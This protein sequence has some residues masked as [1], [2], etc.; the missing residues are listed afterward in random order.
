M[1][2]KSRSLEVI[3]PPNNNI[4]EVKY[5]NKINEGNYKTTNQFG[6]FTDF[7]DEYLNNRRT[8]YDKLY[9]DS[10]K[11][12]YNNYNNNQDYLYNSMNNEDINNYI[13]NK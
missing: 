8:I 13:R 6:D 5:M 3:T 7:V 2:N 9:E 4:I 1:Q 11:K 12:Y 10:F